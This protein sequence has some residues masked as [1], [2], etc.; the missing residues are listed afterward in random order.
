MLQREAVSSVTEPYQLLTAS[1]LSVAGDEWPQCAA[2]PGMHRL[3]IAAFL[4]AFQ[5]DF[6]K[7]IFLHQAPFTELC[8]EWINQAGEL[9]RVIL[10][11]GLPCD[12]SSATW[13]LLPLQLVAVCSVVRSLGLWVLLAEVRVFATYLEFAIAFLCCLLTLA[14]QSLWKNS[15]HFK[16]LEAIFK[17]LFFFTCL[18]GCTFNWRCYT[19]LC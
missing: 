7:F 3:Q 9:Q 16:G 6:Y 15:P 13:L 1:P 18:Y 12:R 19:V 8:Q 11:L 10:S 2:C 4:Q 17:H 14:F 5:R